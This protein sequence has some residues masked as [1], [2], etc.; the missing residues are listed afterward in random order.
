[1]KAVNNTSADLSDALTAQMQAGAVR[2]SAHIGQQ[3]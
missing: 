3:Q 1:M 2:P